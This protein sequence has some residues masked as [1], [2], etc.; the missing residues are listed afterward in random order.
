MKIVE[1][2]IAALKTQA[3]ELAEEKLGVPEA[4]T[5]EGNSLLT[6]AQ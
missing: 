1:H 5:F 3:Q 2:R 4:C 6:C